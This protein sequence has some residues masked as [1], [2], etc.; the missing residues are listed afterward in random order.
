MHPAAFHMQF[1]LAAIFFGA[2][3]AGS[4]AAFAQPPQDVIDKCMKA[5]DFEGCV[6]VMTGK[7]SKPAQ[8]SETKITVDLDKIRNTGNMCPSG[9]GYIGG[10]YCEQ[11]NCVRG[12]NGHDPRLGGKGHSCSSRFNLIFTGNTVR[13]T[14]DERCPFVEPELGRRASCENGL[15]E[16]EIKRGVYIVRRPAGSGVGF[17]YNYNGDTYE[18]VQVFS[19]SPAEDAGIKVGDILTEFDGISIEDSTYK[20]PKIAGRT[21]LLVVE[22]DSE[23]YT[24]KITADEYSYP[25]SV[26]RYDGGNWEFLR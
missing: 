26:W 8:S 20:Q 22:R 15:S 5:A 17:G 12:G 7:S 21:Y 18:I 13:A 23:P 2:L 4:T 19:G 25:D 6:N 10:G 9:F 3:A 11:I 16:P 24:F 1:K 14:T